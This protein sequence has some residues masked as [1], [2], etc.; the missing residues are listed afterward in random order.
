VLSGADTFPA[1]LPYITCLVVEDSTAGVKAGV[2]AGM[3][4]VAIPDKRV[5]TDSDS[6]AF[7]V[8]NSFRSDI[9]SVKTS[10]LDIRL[11]DYSFVT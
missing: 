10:L 9:C 3:C 8:F 11:E 4:V 5:F 7:A 2:A 1:T 6:S